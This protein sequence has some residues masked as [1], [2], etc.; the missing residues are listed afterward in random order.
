MFDYFIHSL[1]TAIN[2]QRGWHTLKKLS[3]KVKVKVK[4]CLCTTMKAYQVQVQLHSLCNFCDRW[5]MIH[6]TQKY[7]TL[8]TYGIK[9]KYVKKGLTTEVT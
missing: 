5:T 4:V 8:G 1:Y 3:V 7:K 2:T 6:W 9:Q